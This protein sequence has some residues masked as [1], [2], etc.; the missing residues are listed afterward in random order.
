LEFRN[1]N[2]DLGNNN[3]ESEEFELVHIGVGHKFPLFSEGVEKMKGRDGAFFEASDYGQGYVFC[4]HFSNVRNA[5]IEIIR[6]SPISMRIIKGE[7]DSMVLPIIKFGNSMVFEMVF[8]PTLYKDAR[9][10]QFTD[11]NN[12][13]SIFLIESN[14]GEVKVIRQTNFPLKM[15]QICK[16][17]WARAILDVNFSEKFNNWYNALQNRYTPEGLWNRA[18]YIGKMGE[19]YNIEEIK[20]PKQKD[21]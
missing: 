11:T 5:E 15:I 7:E 19:T 16:E 21:V 20:Y 18:L 8:D 12:I 1:K 6:K 2:V 13:L 10:L 4:I 17:A 9:A 3:S 14:T